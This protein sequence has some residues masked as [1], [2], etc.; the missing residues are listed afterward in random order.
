MRNN[1][2]VGDGADVALASA[3]H[4]DV[5]GIDGEMAQFADDDVD[6]EGEEVLGAH[7]VEHDDDCEDEEGD[8]GAEE[9]EFEASP[10]ESR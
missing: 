1:N 6:S 3:A 7:Q 9:G 10:L 5:F 4:L 8:A 2:F